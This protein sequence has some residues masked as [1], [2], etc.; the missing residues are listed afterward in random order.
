[1]RRLNLRERKFSLVFCAVSDTPCRPIDEN[2]QLGLCQVFKYRL[3][4]AF[5]YVCR[6]SY[7]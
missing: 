1:M 2:G 3:F 7:Q 6:N 4:A 5:D